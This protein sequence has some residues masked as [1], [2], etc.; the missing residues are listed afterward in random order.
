MFMLLLLLLLELAS[1]PS[2][3]ADERPQILA[4]TLGRG[5]HVR[6]RR[7]VGKAFRLV[8]RGLRALLQGP[9]YALRLP[10]QILELRQLSRQRGAL[11]RE[12][13]RC[14]SYPHPNS[15]LTTPLE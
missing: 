7:V 14:T 11:L 13:H 5:S 6:Q 4:R 9:A 15:P 8:R 12:W 1:G 10:Q 3:D 2:H